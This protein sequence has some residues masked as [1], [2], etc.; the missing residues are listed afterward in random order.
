MSELF[1]K[2]KRALRSD[3]LIKDYFLNHKFRVRISLAL[4]ILLNLAYLVFNLI[5]GIIYRSA[6]FLTVAIYY[7]LLISIRYLI[8]S[9][10]EKPKSREAEILACKKGGI[11][12]FITD[13][14]ISLMIFYSAFFSDTKGYSGAVFS[15]LALHA[16]Y[17]VIIGIF[18]VVK[19]RRDNI[20]THRAAYSV[21]IASASVSFF[22][23]GSALINAFVKNSRISEIL[24]FLLGVSLSLTVLIL[25]YLMIFSYSEY[26]ERNEKNK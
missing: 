17:S 2:I 10:G 16:V 1:L 23:L 4:G 15:V 5:S 3:T 26:G 21:R 24:I 18:G 22:N 13:V 9:P 8:L 20:P 25:A 14:L 6:S 12:L 7:S 11:L 19:G